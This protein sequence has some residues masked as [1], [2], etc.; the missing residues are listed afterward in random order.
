MKLVTVCSGAFVLCAPQPS[1]RDQPM[2]Q[3]KLGTVRRR[4][5]QSYARAV[6]RST[7]AGLRLLVLASVFKALAKL[8]RAN[9][10]HCSGGFAEA[11]LLRRRYAVMKEAARARSR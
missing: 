7:V 2:Q 4:C 9:V 5:N 11:V 8:R 10:A 1:A 6:A 3:R